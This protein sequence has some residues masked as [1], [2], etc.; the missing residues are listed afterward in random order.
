MAAEITQFSRDAWHELAGVI[1]AINSSLEPDRVLDAIAQS[2]SRIMNA[3]A[4][5]VLTLDSRRSKLVFAA[6]FGPTGAELIG[7]EFDAKLGIAGRAVSRRSVEVVRDVAHDPQ[8][9]A[10]F[11]EKSTFVTRELLAA[12]MVFR[13]EVV[14][15]V[16][17]INRRAGSFTD[18]DIEVLRLFAELAATGVS[19]A[20]AHQR[21]QRE[22]EGL[23]ESFASRDSGMIGQSAALADVQKL[24]QRVARSHATVLLL[25]ETGTGK[26]LTARH[27]HVLSERKDRPFIGINC[28]A[29]AETLL[30]SE[31]FGHE[32]GAFT[33]AVARKVGRFELAEG[34]SLFLDEIGDISAATQVK[35]LRV[36]Q[37]REFVRVGGTKTVDCDVRIIA[38][39]NRDLTKAIADG[40][41]REDLY[42]RL[43]VFPINVPPLRERREDIPLLVGHFVQLAAQDLG[44]KTPAI[45]TDATA[46]L[47]SHNWPGNIRELQNVVERMVLMCDGGEI[48]P[49]HLPREIAGA[50]PPAD[51]ND[52]PTGLRGYERAMILQALRANGWNQ[53][54]AAQALGISRDNL[55]YR[56]KKYSISRP[57]E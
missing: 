24:C 40:D 41:F 30:E 55:R 39:T 31:L 56:V 54:R 29:L 9:F 6:A 22:N 36:L 20:R 21:L 43:N 48:L 46:M 23:R 34:G 13:D 44:V 52:A 45:S 14:G 50:A 10:G 42:Y 53:T 8:F 57:R 38:A 25:G 19:N 4:S 37:E 32:K 12:P 51:D 16:E 28:A 3:E 1:T 7:Q 35:L 18:D 33:G 49:M 26:E 27:I 2:A 47:A 5:S 15:V 17:V 11:D